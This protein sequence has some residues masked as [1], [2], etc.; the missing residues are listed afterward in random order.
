MPYL[1]IFRRTTMKSTL[2]IKDL[3]L[4]QI[5]QRAENQHQ[6]EDRADEDE[7]FPARA[8]QGGP[9]Q[10][11]LADVAGKFEDAE[12]AQ[13]AQRPNY[14]QVLAADQQQADPG[15]QHRQQVDDAE[16]AARVA[17]RAVDYREANDVFDRE[18][19]REPPFQ[20]V[21]RVAQLRVHAHYR[22]E[23]HHDDAGANWRDQCDI[24]SFAG[25]IVGPEDDV[26]PARAPCSA[27][28]RSVVGG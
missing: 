5:H 24:E 17:R 9:Q 7:Y 15:R 28:C 11:G 4:D 23:Q 12:D 8:Y 18:Q 22:I 25:H 13:D 2:T 19:Q 16:E 3:A 27:R 26:E 1:I 20:Q 10:V 6:G 14:Q 21:E